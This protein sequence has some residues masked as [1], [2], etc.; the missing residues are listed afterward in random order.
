MDSRRDSGERKSSRRAARAKP[1]LLVAAHDRL[2]NAMSLNM[3]AAKLA[4]RTGDVFHS[5]YA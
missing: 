2:V 1:V 5:I 3:I 4:R